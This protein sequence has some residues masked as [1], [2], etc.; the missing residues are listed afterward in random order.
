MK[1]FDSGVVSQ[2]PISYDLLATVRQIG[3]SRGRQELYKQQRRHA[4][5]TLR[6]IAIIQST[7]SSNRI[8]GVTAPGDRIKAL[9]CKKTTP[10]DRSEQEIAGYRDALNTIHA[11]YEHVPFTTGVV[12]QLHRDL[13]QF[14]P[15]GGGRWK[16]TNNAITELQE[17]GTS[18]VRFDPVQAA[19]TANYVDRLHSE[20]NALWAEGRIDRLILIPAY[21]LDFLRIHPFPDGNGRMGRLLTLLLLYKAGYEVGR[22]VSLEQLVEQTKEDYYDVLYKSSQGWHDGKHSLLPWLEY[23]LG[24]MLAKA[25][26]EFERRVE[27][28]AEGRGAKTELVR[29]TIARMP[30]DFT[31]RDILD[32]CP[33]VS[34]DLVR[35]IL[36]NMKR[37]GKL[38]PTGMGR[39]AGWRKK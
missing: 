34:I 13:Y 12:Q 4:L 32:R 33:T 7:E 18:R 8:E 24:V 35:R 10:R 29:D 11:S 39:D 3:E 27:A 36:H 38:E 15:G 20:F 23:F 2:V 37:E 22:Y 14:V 5:K 21:V 31:V 9:V 17:D 16:S 1:S 30:G 25:Y 6:E 28:V 19:F 26:S